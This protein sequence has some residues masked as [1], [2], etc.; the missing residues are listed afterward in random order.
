MKRTIFTRLILTFCL[1]CALVGT[2]A[3]QTVTGSLVGHVE[4][5]N[6]GAVPGARVVITE[7][8]RGATREALTN[9]EGNYTFSSLDPGVYRV[10]IEGQGFGKFTR[11]DAEININTTVR[12]DAQLAAGNVTG[13]V[14]VSANAVALKTDR[15]DVSQQIRTEQVEELPLS[16]DRN[17]QSV[18]EIVPG[19]SPA[20]PVGS[21]FGN[22][23]GSLT[24]RV[25]GQNERNNNYQL[26]GTI[27]NQTNI[28][29]QTAIVP[30]PEAIQVVDVSTN[31][32][33]AEQGH[34]TGSVINVGIKS[35]TNT[36]HGDAYIFNTNSALAAKPT[37][38]TLDKPETKLTQFG[39]TFGGPIKRD[40]TFFFGDYQ[41]GRDRQGQNT[42]L[43][44]PSLAFR[45][46]D[47][48]GASAIFDPA[49]GTST[50]TNRTQFAS[51]IIPQNR[52]S[53][54]ARAILSRLPAPTRPGNS[55]NFE[56]NGTFIQDR[57]QF[58]VK[59]NHIF[60]D[61]T[62]GFL[63]YSYF[64]AN[65]LDAPSFGILG[66]PTTDGGA[67]AAIGPSRIQS[68]SANV[69]HAFSST[70]VT[71]FRGGFVRVLIQGD[72][73][74]ETDL[75]T[76]VGIPGINTGSFFTGGLPR[77][78]FPTGSFDFLGAATTL[79]FKIAETSLGLS[80]IS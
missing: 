26:D 20:E 68:G 53:P 25:N 74:T 5:V 19:V 47:F 15:A 24:N 61:N 23:G 76:Q 33:D 17:Y 80:Q 41:G 22:P 43:T 1:M 14:E 59:V 38:A 77:I 44:V 27:N 56:T 49:T 66:G 79:P 28:I 29:S 52:I 2:S 30:P 62:N 73:P 36:F 10:E 18:L 7:V 48:T 39:F 67:T 31:A 57:N 11:D 55:N 45:N 4:D 16:P 12:V 42:L 34:A 13:E 8:S 46:G 9:E 35:G 60:N 54:I 72:V 37:F 78:S 40:R 71:E 51:N 70:L 64:Q 65:T 50:G 3:A 32:Y 69:T 21:A 75:A 58:D 6:G 63:R